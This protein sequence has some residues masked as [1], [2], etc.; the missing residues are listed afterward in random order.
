MPAESPHV[1]QVVEFTNAYV[2]LYLL[3]MLSDGET[4]DS[5]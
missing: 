3:A 5:L 2:I 1:L 4:Y